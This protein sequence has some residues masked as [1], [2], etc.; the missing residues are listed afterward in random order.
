MSDFP[1]RKE[2]NANLQFCTEDSPRFDLG[3]GTKVTTPV[4]QARES[5]DCDVEAMTPR[6]RSLQRLL[7]NS[8]AAVMS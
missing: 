8:L 6:R 3:H 2:G 4:A 5:D 1:T 7:C